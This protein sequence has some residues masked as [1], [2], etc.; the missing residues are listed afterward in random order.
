MIATGYVR[1]STKSEETTVSLPDQARHIERYCTDKGLALSAIVFHDG[2]SGGERYRWDDIHSVL[3]ATGSEVLVF[4]YLDR[5]SRDSAGLLQ[6]AEELTKR[7]IEIHEATQGRI[8][9]SDPTQKLMLAVRSAM[10]ENYKNVIQYKTRRALQ[11]KKENGQRYTNLP[12][13]GYSYQ[14]GKMIE[15]AEEQRALSIIAACQ[16]RGFG[17]RRTRAALV[18]AGYIGRMGLATI[19]RT[20]QLPDIKD[21]LPASYFSTL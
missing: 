13:L 17:A 3:T 7:G 9:T 1:R 19:H 20:L 8:D 14:N 16:Q 21:K 15:D 6:N 11:Y 5:L 10:D 4:G 18:K 12:P 2:V